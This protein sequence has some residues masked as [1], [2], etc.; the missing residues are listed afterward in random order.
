M[1]IQ[2]GAQQPP[3]RSLLLTSG[4]VPGSVW[5]YD[6]NNVAPIPFAMLFGVSTV[7]HFYQCL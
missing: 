2:V 6:P 5:F 1:A 4:P 3:I 7:L